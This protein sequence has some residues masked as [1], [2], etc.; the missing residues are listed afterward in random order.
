MYPCKAAKYVF[1]LLLLWLSGGLNES[2]AQTAG[3]DSTQTDST[4]TTDRPAVPQRDILDLLRAV[5]PG[6]FLKERDTT[7]LQAGR[8]LVWIIPQVGYSIQTSFQAQVLG[9]IAIRRPSA[10]VSTLVSSVIYTANNQ[11]LLTSTLNYW[12][13]HNTW[14]LT[15]DL[16]LMHYPQPTYGLG[17]NTSTDHVINMD[18]NYLRAHATL[19]RRIAPNLYGGLGLQLDLHWNIKSWDARHERTAI[20]RYPYGITGR[21]VSSGPILNLLYDNRP[22]SISPLGGEYISVIFR[23]NVTWLGSDTH[24]QSMLLDLRKYVSLST[25]KPENVLAFWSYNALTINGNPPFLDLPATA[26]DTY[27]NMGRG[28]IQGRYRGKDL[29]YMET[30]FRFGITANR[31]LGG[32]VFVNSQTV[33]NTS[34]SAASPEQKLQFGHVAPATG[35]GL[36]FRMNKLSRTNLA[37]DY[38]VGTRGSRGIYFNLG[39]VF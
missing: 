22:N 7:K 37:L 30:E 38:S 28:Y 14:N 4:V 1:A 31:L 6:R 9:N 33:S 34:T 20:S 23:D 24:Y 13:P 21:S 11:Q 3:V 26:W 25:R 18:Y 39:E 27:G 10:N 32:V 12:F 16:R 17:M 29:L 8:P 19:L 15:S 36:R 5:L 35:L 2:I